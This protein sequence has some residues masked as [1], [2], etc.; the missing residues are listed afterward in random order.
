MF[1][2]MLG[3]LFGAILA[4]LYAPANG[5]TTRTK[6]RDKARKTQHDVSDFVQKKRKHYGNKLLGIKHDMGKLTEKTRESATDLR[7]KAEQQKEVILNKTMELKSKAVEKAEELKSK[8]ANKAEELKAKATDKADELKSKA[9]DKAEE[10]RTKAAEQ[11][12]RLV[13]F[14]PNPK[15]SEQPGAYGSH[16]TGYPSQS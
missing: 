10:I 2:F 6:L 14:S 13:D 15:Q 11:T 12:E 4:L 1:Q 7:E 3:G 5:R 16:E 9:A 8:A